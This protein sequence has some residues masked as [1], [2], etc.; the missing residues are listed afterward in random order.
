MNQNRIYQYIILGLV[1]L[2]LIV[3]AV[4]LLAESQP[5]YRQSPKNIRSEVIEILR[6]NDDQIFH[7]HDLADEH[8][9]RMKDIDRRQARLLLPYFESLADSSGEIDKD[10]LLNHY[11]LS[12]KE[13]VEV[14]YQHFQEIKKLLNEDQLSEF[15][16]F[17]DRVIDG[18]LYN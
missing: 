3:L 2:N 4:F 8:K 7:F 15:N 14:T 11:Q 12:E 5:R 1:V 13:K 17:M 6:L 18:L 10:S 16:E 9:R